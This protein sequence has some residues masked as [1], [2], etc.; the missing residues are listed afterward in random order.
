[1]L[2]IELA[3][4]TQFR[5]HRFA[6]LLWFS[7][8]RAAL[9]NAVPNGLYRGSF[10]LDQF[11]QRRNARSVVWR[12][13]AAMLLLAGRNVRQSYL[14]IGQAYPLEF[15]QHQ[16]GRRLCREEDSET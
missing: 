4:P 3:Q 13:Q 7:I 11:G 5:E 1:M 15:A 9:H 12:A 16:A 10:V 6:D 8:E 2:R 14:R